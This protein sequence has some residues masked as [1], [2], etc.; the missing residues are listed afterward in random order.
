MKVFPALSVLFAVCLL[1]GPAAASDDRGVDLKKAIEFACDKVY[2]SLVNIAVVAKQFQGGRIDRF[3][4]AGSGVIVSPAGHVLTNYH[5]AGDAM[6]ITCTLPNRER[7]EASVVAHDPLT[8]LSVLKLDLSS[9]TDANAPLP[10]ATLGNSDDLK[11]GDYVLAMGNPMGLSSSMTLGI[12][13]N[14]RRVFTSFTGAEAEELDLGEGQTTGI[15]TRWIQHDALILPGNSGGPLVNLRGE[16]VGINELGGNG[17]GFAI[18]STLAGHVLNQALMY[19]EVRRGWLGFSIAPVGNLDRDTGALVSSIWPGGPAENAGVRPG[20][21]ILS[22]NGEAVRARFFEEV[23][24]VL[25]RVADLQPGSSA[26]IVVE[27]GGKAVEFAI[28]VERMEKYLGEEAEV[29]KW[30]VTIRGITGPM[31]L[32]RRYPDAKGVLVKSVRPGRPADE[33]KPSIERDDVVIKVQGE[34]VSGIG[35]FR[36]LLEKNADAKKL[37]VELRRGDE[38]IVTVL[39]FKDPDAVKGGGELPKAWLGVRTQVLTEDVAAALSL[40]NQKGFRITQVFAA[41]E[42]EKAGLRVG[43]IIASLNGQALNA[44]RVQDDQMLRRKIENLDIGSA[45]ELSILRDGKQMSVKVVLEETPSTAAE[46]KTAADEEFEFTVRE[47]TFA[48][49]IEKKLKPD[50]KGLV[51]AGVTSG[52]WASLCGLADGDILLSVCDRPVTDLNS[53]KEVMKEVKAGKPRRVKAFIQ[54][55]FKTAYIFME[56]DWSQEEGKK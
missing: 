3:P 4:A 21:I 47:I 53:F 42:A 52:G 36:K 27:R 26:K 5:V 46:I 49:R 55:R 25:K 12:V 28:T 23:P 44:Y 22:I 51:V 13:S 48:D 11:V 8:D 7:I 31:A 37:V 14:P 56:P 50:L 6:R 38:L 45:A 17:V 29:K 16:V 34:D 9:R 30:G 2:P 43:D 19:G 40:K 54:R 20:D 39:K 33:A 35:E 18:P 24:P 41:T 10:F 15:F 32:M 1:S